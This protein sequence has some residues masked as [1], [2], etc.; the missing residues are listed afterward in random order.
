[1]PYDATK[2]AVWQIAEAAEENMPTPDDWRA[3]LG[4]ETDEVLT[5][6]RIARLDFLNIMRRLKNKP[7]NVRK[8][9][10]ISEKYSKTKIL[11]Q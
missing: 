1:M 3:K 2:M 11:M 8:L 4:L 9:M 7:E 6:G 10:E 5:Y